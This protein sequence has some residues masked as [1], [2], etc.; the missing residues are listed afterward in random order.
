MRKREEKKKKGTREGSGVRREKTGG[1]A[2]F[3]AHIIK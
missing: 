1:C 3:P 2:V